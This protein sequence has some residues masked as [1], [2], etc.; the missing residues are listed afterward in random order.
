MVSCELLVELVW[1]ALRHRGGLS[2]Q[3]KQICGELSIVAAFWILAHDKKRLAAFAW[4]SVIR[5]VE[6]YWTSVSFYFEAYR[7]FLF[8]GI[9]RTSHKWLSRCQRRKKYPGLMKLVRPTSYKK[10]VETAVTLMNRL[11][12]GFV[13]YA[14]LTQRKDGG[15]L[16][17]TWIFRASPNNQHYNVENILHK[18][19]QN[20]N[21]QLWVL[22]MRNGNDEPEIK[23]WLLTEI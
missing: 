21:A 4:M 13:I 6:R 1:R 15:T 8:W 7:K 2:R 12:D 23:R 22:I 9:S 18:A 3:K 19:I 17:V 20:R 5:A 10:D 16:W 11:S 14:I